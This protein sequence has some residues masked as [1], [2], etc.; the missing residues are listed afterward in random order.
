MPDWSRISQIVE[1][2]C[3]D[4]LQ[5]G[6]AR[7]VGGGCI[8]SA[9]TM[10][11]GKQAVFIKINT[12]AQVRMFEA[13]AEGLKELG[14]CRTMRVPEVICYGTE[15]ND[16]YLVMDYLKLGGS[17]DAGQFGEALADMHRILQSISGKPRYGWHRANTIGSTP[18]NN[19]Y[20]EDWQVFWAKH[21]L[22][23]QLELARKKGADT[24]LLSQGEQLKNSLGTFFD[25]YVPEASLLH[26][27]LWSGNYAYSLSGQPVIFDPAVY[28]GDRETDLAMT[29]LFGGFSANFYTAYQSAYP[30]DAGYKTRKKLYNLYHIL[31]HFNLFGGGY[32]SQARSMISQLLGEL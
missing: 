6:T 23:F 4:P 9:Y 12:A 22:G 28:F 31:N 1:Q 25:G 15:G 32:L 18:Q 30:L 27:D 2:A 3:G 5:P 14:R 17:G 7:P 24:Q 11:A 13:E 8:N 26:G 29:E 20:E 16:A 21:R 19:D 10:Q